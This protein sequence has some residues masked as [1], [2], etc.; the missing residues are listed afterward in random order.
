VGAG[1]GRIG[2]VTMTA[3]CWGSALRPT[4]CVQSMVRIPYVR[5]DDRDSNRTIGG[6]ATACFPPRGLGCEAT[7]MKRLN[8]ASSEFP[9]QSGER[10]QATAIKQRRRRHPQRYRNGYIINLFPDLL[11]I[12]FNLSSSLSSAH[13][14]LLGL[15]F[16][17]DPTPTEQTRSIRKERIYRRENSLKLRN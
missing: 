10:G 17:R 5:V 8:G 15:V 16:H 14:T 3:S 11:L 7:R 13:D 2:R 1:E 9:Y 4:M 6:R 12:T